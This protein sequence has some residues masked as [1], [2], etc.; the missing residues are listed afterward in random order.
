VR[1]RAYAVGA[2]NNNCL[3]PLDEMMRTFDELVRAGKVRRVGLPNVP[4]WCARRAQALAEFRGY[5]SVSAP[6]LEYSLV[7]RSI[8]SEFVPLRLAHGV[9]T[10]VWSPLASGPLS[11]KYRCSPSGPVGHGMAQVA[12]NWVAHRPG[13][14]SVIVGATRLAQPEDNL[15]AF[16]FS[17]PDELTASLDRAS[18]SPA[19]FPYSFFTP[20][21]QAMLA[22]SHAVR[23][24][25]EHYWPRT[26]IDDAVA[27]R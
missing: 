14:A 7:E 20:G 18:G 17:R 21:M 9:G 6:Q 19:T 13:V 25:P 2:A 4:A 15:G 3:T 24:K 8:E 23:D 26:R 10:M 5:E 27:R 22:G 11:G 1:R 12:L 16:E